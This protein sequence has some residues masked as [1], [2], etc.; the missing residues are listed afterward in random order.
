MVDPF[1]LWGGVD[2]SYSY[3]LWTGLNFVVYFVFIIW[4]FLDGPAVGKECFAWL[5]WEFCG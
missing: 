4:S 2:Q 3:L 5:A 1:W